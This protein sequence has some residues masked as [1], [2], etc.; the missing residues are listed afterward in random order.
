MLLLLNVSKKKDLQIYIHKASYPSDLHMEHE[1]A[2]GDIPEHVL[3]AMF[4]NYYMREMYHDANPFH[5]V[6]EL[7][8]I[9]YYPH[10]RHT[11]PDLFVPDNKEKLDSHRV[12]KYTT[13]TAE[14]GPDLPFVTEFNQT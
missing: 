4:Q 1:Y 12:A 7:D 3:R 8:Q 5:Y 13:W 6:R 14:N 11:N 9:V 2:L 10:F